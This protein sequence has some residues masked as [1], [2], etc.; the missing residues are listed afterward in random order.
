MSSFLGSSDTTDRGVRPPTVGGSRMSPISVSPCPASPRS[1][2]FASTVPL[3]QGGIDPLIHIC[4]S[5]AS[6]SLSLH[7][8]ANMGRTAHL[9]AANGDL[10]AAQ[11]GLVYIDEIDKL[12]ASGTGGKDKRPGVQHALLKMLEGTAAT[13][14]PQGRYE[15]PAQSGISFDTTNVLFISPLRVQFLIRQQ[16]FRF[17]GAR[18]Y[19]G[20]QRQ[21]DARPRER[22]VGHRCGPGHDSQPVTSP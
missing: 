20:L 10:D 6:R 7:L 4:G 1:A 18:R 12:R 22:A 17:R 9:Q 19:L 15:H 21:S 14:P 3:Y 8:S 11:R 16:R 13:V 5:C 2:T